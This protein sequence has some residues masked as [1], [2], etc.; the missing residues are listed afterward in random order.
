MVKDENKQTISID[1][2]DKQSN[3]VSVESKSHSL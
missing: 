1:L 2:T 3:M